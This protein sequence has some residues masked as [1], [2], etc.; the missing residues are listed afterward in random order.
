MFFQINNTVALNVY[1]ARQRIKDLDIRLD[2]LEHELE[3]KDKSEKERMRLRKE[4]R[5]L[6][7]E[8]DRLKADLRFEENERYRTTPR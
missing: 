2:H 6:D 8:R 7:R 1:K 3:E 4:I 5:D